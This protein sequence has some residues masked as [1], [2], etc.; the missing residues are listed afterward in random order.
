[1]PLEAAH[2]YV[3]CQTNDDLPFV[4]K[5]AGEGQ[6]V[7]GTDYGHFDASSELDAISILKQ[8]KELPR[9]TIARIVDTNPRALYGLD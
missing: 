9:D 3:T 2:V 5:H 7:I 6:I 1:M 8:S 4:L